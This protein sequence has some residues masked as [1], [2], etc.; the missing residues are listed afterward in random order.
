MYWM[1]A[2]QTIGLLWL[3]LSSCYTTR[4]LYCFGRSHR[5]LILLAFKNH[6]RTTFIN[7]QDQGQCRLRLCRRCRLLRSRWPACQACSVRLIVLLLRASTKPLFLTN[8]SIC[9]TCRACD[10]GN[11][12]ACYSVIEETKM[13]HSS[14]V[15]AC[16]V[17]V[18]VSHPPAYQFPRSLGPFHHTLPS[19]RAG[20]THER[21][22]RRIA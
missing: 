22:E 10:L 15:C 8:R 14:S 18:F 16:R 19:V 20:T 4:P 3:Q 13:G 5:R 11:V 7:L 9:C 2:S 12:P 21:Y 1:G 6:E 17:A